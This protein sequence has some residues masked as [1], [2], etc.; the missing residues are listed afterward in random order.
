MHHQNKQGAQKV[1]LYLCICFQATPTVFGENLPD[2]RGEDAER[3]VVPEQRTVSWC[4]YV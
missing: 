4:C 2:E 3:N 1:L